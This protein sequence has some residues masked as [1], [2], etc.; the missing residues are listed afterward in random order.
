M[1]NMQTNKVED[2]VQT[3]L[4]DNPF[5]PPKGDVCFINDL[6]PELL[7][8][9]FEVG[10]ED[11]DSNDEDDM[12]DYLDTFYEDL[13]EAGADDNESDSDA[14]EDEE[15]C[16]EGDEE[17]DDEDGSDA[18]ESSDS[19]SPSFQ[20][21]VSHVCRHWREVALSTPSIWTTIEVTPECCPPYQHVS[22]MLERSKGLPIDVLVDSGLGHRSSILYGLLVPHIHR[23][24]TVRIDVSY[25]A[26][27]YAFLVAVSDPA[28][29]AA[30]QLTSLELYHHEDS[31]E[32]GEFSSFMHPKIGDHFV[33]FGG[34]APR[35]TS[36]VLWGVHIDWDQPWIAS[37]ST[38]KELQLAYHPDD[39]RPSWSQFASILRSASSLESLSLEIDLN[40]P[41]QLPKVTDLTLAFHSERRAI[42]LLHKLYLP[43]LKE[44]ALNFDEGDYTD[45]VDE[46]AGQATS[47]PTAQEQ[48]RSLLNKIEK[49]KIAGLPC[50]P[51]CA[52][53]LY[54]ELQN[55]RLLN[56]S[57]SFVPETFLYIL[58][59]SRTPAGP[60]DIYLPR[61]VTLYVAGTSGDDIREVVEKRK[62]LGVPLESL[63]ME[64]SCDLTK[65]DVKWL[66]ENVT[67]F[68]IF[69][70]SDDEDDNGE[71]V[72]DYEDMPEE[73]DEW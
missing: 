55:L 31:S 36:V 51:E 32:R 24:R 1:G 66:R 34:S 5:V 38:L 57:M 26:H 25:Y 23:W 49:L 19:I 3:L 39:V 45:F 43:A 28:I 60:N 10:A 18:S 70:G 41:I 73:F 21:I 54:S 15:E 72:I 69:E 46:L 20:V 33:L 47:L 35:L 53:R 7:S 58:S 42:G 27:V 17:T 8:H 67:T 59:E 12:E 9:I 50:R 37:S 63:H 2:D 11:N 30:P 56:I 40:S 13:D 68:E 71:L 44:L 16:S 48:P 4:P 62:E 52:R 22:T 65:R 29:P 14:D 6:P 64:Q 61:L